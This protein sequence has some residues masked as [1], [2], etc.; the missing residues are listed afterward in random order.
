[1]QS[2]ISLAEVVLKIG[3]V[4]IQHMHGVCSC[5]Y[6]DGFVATACYVYV[7]NMYIGSREAPLFQNHFP[8]LLKF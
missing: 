3:A 8:P 2:Y 6:R 1:M 7:R 4:F 5:L